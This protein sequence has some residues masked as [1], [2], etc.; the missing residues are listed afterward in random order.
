MKRM[1][2]Q[3]SVDPAGSFMGFDATDSEDSD[4][5]DLELGRSTINQVAKYT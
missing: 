4:T 5:S 2:K 1:A 3:L